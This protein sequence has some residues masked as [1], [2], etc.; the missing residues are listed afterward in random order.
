MAY[1]ILTLAADDSAALDDCYAVFAVLRPHLDLA[2]FRARVLL[3]YQEGY[4]IAYIR[5]DGRVVA[6]A[7]YRIA[8]FL[9]WGRTLYLDD[10]ITHP[11]MKKAG[12]AQALMDALMATA[13]AEGCDEF[14][15]DTGYQRHDAHRFYLKNG[16]ELNCHHLAKKLR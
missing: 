7:G 3:Q 11:E 2:T 16:L 14:H 9:A 1:D 15:L 5:V 8:H 13:K 4:R 6:A 10:L 12:L